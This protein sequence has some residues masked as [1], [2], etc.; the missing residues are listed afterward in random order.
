MAAR[1]RMKRLEADPKAKPDDWNTLEDDLR[2]LAEKLG[3]NG[4]PRRI[5]GFDISNISGTFVV[6]SMVSFWQGRPD[7]SQYRRFRMK[8][9]IGQNDFASMAE[10]IRRRYSRL[11]KDAPGSPPVQPDASLEETPEGEPEPV[12]TQA[13][14]HTGTSPARAAR[15][16]TG[17]FPDLILI[18]GG[19]GQL[20]AALEELKKLDLSHLPVLGLAKEFEE[21]Y[22]PDVP[23]PLHLSLDSGALKLLQRVRDES[24]RFANTYNAQLRLKRI[25]ESVLDEFPGIGAARKQALLKRFGSVERL[26]RATVEQIAEVSGFGG[27][28]ATR[29]VDFLRARGGSSAKI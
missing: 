22:L 4:P 28:M 26:R 1:L 20:N 21:I 18:D 6:S 15:P 5:E 2:E 23:S 29:L 19:R 8:T 25:S 14:I 27:E 16:A 7:R 9:V 11:K 12:P 3:L 17:G 13:G 10:T 24:H